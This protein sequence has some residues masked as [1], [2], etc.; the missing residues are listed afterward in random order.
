MLPKFIFG[1]TR[2][3]SWASF[4]LVLTDSENIVHL[5]FSFVKYYCSSGWLRTCSLPASAFL[6][7]LFFFSF[8]LPVLGIISRALHTLCKPFTNDLH[9]LIFLK[10]VFLFWNN[11]CKFPWLVPCYSSV[12]ISQST[13]IP[14]PELSNS[15]FSF[16]FKDCGIILFTI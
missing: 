16:F 2:R 3:S 15:C 11:L 10:Q 6:I 9:P 8:P 5:N 4:T 1:Y 13:G 7:I 14:R 12:S